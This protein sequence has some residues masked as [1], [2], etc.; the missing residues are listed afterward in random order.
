MM[1]LITFNFVDVSSFRLW[2]RARTIRLKHVKFAVM[3]LAAVS[4]RLCDR[5]KALLHGTRPGFGSGFDTQS[6]QSSVEHC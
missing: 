4:V 6:I 2:R 1:K 3:L 5:C